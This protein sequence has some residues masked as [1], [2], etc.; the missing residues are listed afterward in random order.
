MIPISLIE[1]SL[2]KR[3]MEKVV[4]LHELGAASAVHVNKTVVV[5]KQRDTHLEYWAILM[6]DDLVMLEGGHVGII[7]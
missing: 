7:S 2:Y 3:I 6:H 1:Q 4:K 5:V